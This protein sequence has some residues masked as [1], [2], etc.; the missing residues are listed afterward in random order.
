M[1][2][3]SLNTPELSQFSSQESFA[4]PIDANFQ[5]DDTDIGELLEQLYDLAQVRFEI[6][7][8]LYFNQ[9]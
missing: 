4:G 6:N 5:P 9:I 7:F 2:Q 1:E 3:G 8:V